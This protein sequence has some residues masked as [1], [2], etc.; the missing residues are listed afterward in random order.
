EERR[1]AGPKGVLSARGAQAV[2][3]TV[4]Q[5]PAGGPDRGAGGGVV[6]AGHAGCGL[7]ADSGGDWGGAGFFRVRPG[8]A[9]AERE[10]AIAP[11]A[12][13]LCRRSTRCAAGLG[14]AA[15]VWAGGRIIWREGGRGVWERAPRG[16]GRGAAG[17]GPPPSP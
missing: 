17:G 9:G 4:A 7:A 6:D 2:C 13:G 16:G 15:A 10:R 1:A 14:D 12:G 11:R 5:R 8:R 3:R